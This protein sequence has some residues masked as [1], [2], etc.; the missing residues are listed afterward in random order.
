MGVGEKDIQRVGV[1]EDGGGDRVRC[2]VPATVHACT[3][4][5]PFWLK[6]HHGRNIREG[7]KWFA[8]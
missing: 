7:C 5:E 6:W 8:I 4:K 3:I 2:F 1:T